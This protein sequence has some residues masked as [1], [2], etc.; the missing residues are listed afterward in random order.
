MLVAVSHNKSGR[1]TL[2]LGLA[3]EN[4]KLLKNDQPIT[5]DLGEIEELKGWDLV[6]LGPEDMVR[7]VAHYGKKD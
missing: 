6:I 5:K 4:L 1:K 7:F 3:E 2:I